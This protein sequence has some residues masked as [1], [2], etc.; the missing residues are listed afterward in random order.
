[1]RH[2]RLPSASRRLS[3]WL[4]MRV[5][6]TFHRPSPAT[7]RFTSVALTALLVAWTLLAPAALAGDDAPGD[8]REVWL[9][10]ARAGLAQSAPAPT[11][12]AVDGQGNVY[13]TDYAFDRV[14]KYGPDGTLLGQWGG[15][16]T[17]PGQFSRPFG[18]AVDDHNAVYVVDQL[19]NRVQKFGAEGAFLAAWGGAGSAAGQLQTPFG[20]ASAPAGIYVADFNNNR[21]QLF[22]LDGQPVRAFGSAG[23]AEGQFLRP[24]GV[25]VDREGNVYVSDHFNDRV[26]KFGPDGRYLALIGGPTPASGPPTP[27]A[28]PTPS[29]TPAL[30][31][32]QVLRPEGLALDG[33]G[34]LYV[35]DYGRDRVAKFGPDG[36]FLF[37]WGSRGQGENELLGPKG[38]AVDPTS[39]WIY[40]ADTGNGRVQRFRPDGA[41]DTTWMLP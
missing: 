17:G 34:S 36:R 8:G 12:V 18:I 28:V 21:V 10:A 31:E 32:G 5:R 38:I 30:P 16:G 4:G 33:E 27:S 19:N 9:E 22:S 24:A 14:L 37:A 15:Y 13:V 11:S 3:R 26:Q 39:G 29:A 20:A 1:M 2:R 7:L 23:S 25:A 40:V 6:R 35:A 41:Y